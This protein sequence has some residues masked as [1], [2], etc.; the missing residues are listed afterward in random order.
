M[1]TILKLCGHIFFRAKHFLCICVRLSLFV[2]PGRSSPKDGLI[3]VCKS[4]NILP[5]PV[6]NNC[7]MAIPYNVYI[8]QQP[9]LYTICPLTSPPI[10]LSISQKVS[11]LSCL[12]KAGD[13]CRWFHPNVTGLEA[14]TLLLER[15]FDGSFLA[16]P[17]RSNPGDFTLSVRYV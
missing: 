4:S 11:E 7:V 13:C 2:C 12:C 3:F 9:R 8:L 14:E 15:G 5:R 16:R 1:N 6:C 10:F 17:S